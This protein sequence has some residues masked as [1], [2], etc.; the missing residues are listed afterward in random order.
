MEYHSQDWHER[1]WHSVSEQAVLLSFMCKHLSV[2]RQKTY[3][4]STRVLFP[5]YFVLRG[6]SLHSCVTGLTLLPCLFCGCCVSRTPPKS[7]QGLCGLTS[8]MADQCTLLLQVSAHP[9]CRPTQSPKRPS[10]ANTNTTE[11]CRDLVNIIIRLFCK[12]NVFGLMFIGWPVCLL[13]ALNNVGSFLKVEKC[14]IEGI[15][16]CQL[17]KP[18]FQVEELMLTSR[19]KRE[20]IIFSLFCNIKVN[21]VSVTPETFSFQC[22]SIGVTETPGALSVSTRMQKR[23]LRSLKLWLRVSC[24][25][26]NAILLSYC[27][28]RGVR[29]QI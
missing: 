12:Y 25:T 3:H 2:K 4:M 24:Q 20:S 19:K 17:S 27:R 8:S 14:F 16:F 28:S 10:A 1:Q 13:M 6:L 9:L 11:S 29:K 18:T 21:M 23:K 15:Y 26:R 22:Q 5:V 7:G